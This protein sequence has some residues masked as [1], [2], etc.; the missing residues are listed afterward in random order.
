MHE[1]GRCG[2]SQGVQGTIL[3]RTAAR[4]FWTGVMGGY[5]SRLRAKK[6]EMKF[7]T[8]SRPEDGKPDFQKMLG[9]ASLGSPG[10]GGALGHLGDRFGTILGLP[11]PPGVW[12]PLAPWPPIFLLCDVMC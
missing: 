2:R 11:G 12:T 9:I 8:G 5:L 4:F 10:P 6:V 3:L 1:S 7:R